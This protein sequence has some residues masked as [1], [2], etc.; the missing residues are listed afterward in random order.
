M[1]F[2]IALQGIFDALLQ[3]IDL[4][5]LRAQIGLRR[6][7]FFTRCLPTPVLPLQRVSGGGLHSLL[8]LRKV[9]LLLLGTLGGV[10]HAALQI[11]QLLHGVFKTTL[12]GA[13]KSLC[14]LA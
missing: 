5:S 6:A 3:G 12:H 11:I 7:Q 10:N 9:L 4:I 13:G 2:Q 14:V 1:A 8:Q